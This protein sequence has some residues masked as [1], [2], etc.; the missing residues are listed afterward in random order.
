MLWEEYYDKQIDWAP[1]TKI[2]R[3]STLESFGSPEEVAEVIVDIAFYDEAGATKLLKKSI[4]AGVKFTGSQLYDFG[5]CCDEEI[6]HQAVRC[7]A[8]QFTSNDIQELYTA[9]DDAFLVDIALK[10]QIKLPECLADFE[11]KEFGYRSL[12]QLKEEFDYIL[13]YLFVAQNHLEKAYTFSMWDISRNHREW[14]VLK[15][16]HVEDAQNYITYA[17]N[18]WNLL[19]FPEKGNSFFPKV[20]PCISTADMHSDFWISGFWLKVIAA[21]RIKSLLA[22]VKQAIRAIQELR[23]SIR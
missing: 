17:I 2:N 15:Y 3:I 9:C 6:F 21:R 20:F 16:S 10:Y 14:S 1:R 18:A 22:I 19:D 11:R 8:D 4:A 5:E 13:E 23:N 12:T 7:S